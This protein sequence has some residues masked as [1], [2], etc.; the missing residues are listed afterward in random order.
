MAISVQGPLRKWR[1]R[2]SCNGDR[3]FLYQQ[4]QKR[5]H[6]QRNNFSG[7]PSRFNMC[8]R[9]L[10]VSIAQGMRPDTTLTKKTKVVKQRL[11]QRLEN[12]YSFR[13]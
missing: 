7:L 1:R 5:V 9:I 3:Y 6:I 2:K 10:C 13:G 11:N 4:E 12:W 8:G